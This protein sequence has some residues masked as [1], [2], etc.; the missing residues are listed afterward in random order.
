[1]KTSVRFL[2]MLLAVLMI[3]SA[4]LTASAA[5]AETTANSEALQLLVDLGIFGGYDD[6]SLKPDQLVERDEMAKIIFV[7]YTTF[8]DAGAGADSFKDVADNHWANGFISWCSSRGIVGGYG[9]G[10]FGPDDHVTYDQALKMVCGALGYTEWDS[11]LWPTD[12]RTKALND[13]NL[14]E[15]I[16]G[17]KGSDEITRA[18]IAQIVYNALFADMNETK[19][20]ERELI[21]GTGIFVKLPVAKTLAV[22]V[23]KFS[24]VLSYVSAAGDIGFAKITDEDVDVIIDEVGEFTLEDLG[25][26]E[27]ADNVEEL[28]NA[29]VRII[30]DSNAKE[31]NAESIIATS[32]TL[33][34][35]KDA[36]ITYDEIKDE[37]SINGKAVDED[38]TVSCFV[39][40][41]GVVVDQIALD[42][43][44]VPAEDTIYTAIAYDYDDDGEYD[45]VIWDYLAACKVGTVTDKKVSFALY[46]TE[47]YSTINVEDITTDVALAEDDV[48][49]VSNLFDQFTVIEKVEPVVAAASRYSSKKLTLVDVG[50]VAINGVVF[51]PNGI[52]TVSSSVMDV[53]DKGEVTKSTYYIY[54][55]K[56]FGADVVADESDLQFAII[57]YINEPVK[58]K[59]DEDTK[60]Y[61][62]NYTAVVNING[63]EQTVK[64]NPADSI[65]GLKMKN[66]ADLETILANYGKAFIDE[67]GNIGETGKYLYNRYILASYKVDEDGLY[68]FTTGAEHED[69]K[70]YPAGST[71]KYNKR[72]GLYGIYDAEGTLLAGRVK[73]D[74]A[75]VVYY[76]YKKEA[77]GDHVYLG[78]YT[79]SDLPEN[80]DSIVANSVI[81]ATYNEENGFSNV[82]LLV[83]DED[84]IETYEKAKA[85]YRTDAREFFYCYQSSNQMMASDGKSVNY[86]HFMRSVYHG[87][88][89]PETANEQP[90]AGKTESGYL[91][92]WD[93][94]N[95]TYV[96]VTNGTLGDLGITSLGAY[97]LDEII[98]GYIITKEEKFNAGIKIDDAA[99]MWALGGTEGSIAVL[100]MAGV[101]KSIDINKEFRAYH[102]NNEPQRMIIGTRIN[103][104]GEEVACVIIFQQFVYDA[105]GNPAR[106]TTSLIYDKFGY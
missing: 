3:A 80:L 57:N 93:D 72:T 77:T 78:S 73:I 92:F 104:E 83:T 1:M 67:E 58:G 24:E 55:G 65:N 49:I 50:E 63:K 34:A 47:E 86:T 96:K 48:V 90:G 94:E 31:I 29:N 82:K 100:D 22:D 76:T 4:A 75:A 103:D 84:S 21:P 41:D 10:N 43:D 9:D 32:V 6:G 52:C 105:A 33:T 88:N 59:L 19:L 69:Y 106:N 95:K 16:K 7:L 87:T 39:T 11:K 85:D 30:Y 79:K 40:A 74:D 68:T 13:L 102:G 97:T 71:V 37:I 70:V 27:Y 44:T 5:D 12:V 91:Y 35:T 62:T 15:N 14:G 53:D 25:L 81:Y 42:A 20:Q 98:N 101:Q 61:T 99:S 54:D 26:E 17:V 51:V 2:S 38:E 23:W 89:L 8:A 18:Q 64:V 28:F 66:T 36:T 46:G 60:T 56:V 45:A